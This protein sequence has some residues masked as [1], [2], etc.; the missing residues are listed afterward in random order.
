MEN[1]DSGAHR[2]ELERRLLA[3]MR[4]KLDR[5]DE[6]YP[7]GWEVTDFVVIARFYTAPESDDTPQPWYGGP[8][9]G[10]SHNGF[11]I[12]SSTSYTSTRT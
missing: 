4:G 9:P 2:E 6:Q 1:G 11:T 10:W 8:F 5:L 7:E 3:L 12:G